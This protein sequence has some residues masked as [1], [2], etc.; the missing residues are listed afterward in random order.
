MPRRMVSLSWWTGTKSTSK[1]RL[2]SRTTFTQAQHIS[3]SLSLLIIPIPVQLLTFSVVSIVVIY[4]WYRYHRDGHNYDC[5]YQCSMYEKPWQE[6]PPCARSANKDQEQVCQHTGRLRW[7]HDLC[8]REEFYRG[9]RWQII[10]GGRMWRK[11]DLANEEVEPVFK[12]GVDH[13]VNWRQ[14]TRGDPV[15]GG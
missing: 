12:S 15:P 4:W 3:S 10:R 7:N 13:G 14:C 6:K 1:P 2:P 11:D 9:R 8:D 5:E